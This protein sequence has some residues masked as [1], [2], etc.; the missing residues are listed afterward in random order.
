MSTDSP[1]GPEW[2]RTLAHG[3]RARLGNTFILHGNTLDVVPVPAENGAPRH[4]L[5]LNA[6]LAEQWSQAEI[7]RYI[8]TGA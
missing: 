1:N 5:P 3:I 2:S 4:F 7:V 6:W 8:E